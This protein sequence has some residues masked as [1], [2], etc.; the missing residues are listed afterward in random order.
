[1]VNDHRRSPS[2]TYQGSSTSWST[3][4]IAELTSGKPNRQYRTYKSRKRWMV[5]ANFRCCGGDCCE[6]RMGSLETYDQYGEPKPLILCRHEFHTDCTPPAAVLSTHLK[7]QIWS[8][9][10]GVNCFLSGCFRI[11][12]SM[13]PANFL[14]HLIVSLA[15]FQTISFRAKP[16]PFLVASSS[17]T[18]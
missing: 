17:L 3:L 16:P 18:T 15:A 9:P 13:P 5:S 10:C 6:K 8:W 1:M 14:S 12:C 11:I 4:M 2:S 7:R